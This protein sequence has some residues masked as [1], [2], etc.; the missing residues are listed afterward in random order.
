M[1]EVVVVHFE[2]DVSLASQHFR[3][4]FFVVVL[5]LEIVHVENG[6]L[7]T[8][9]PGR[10]RGNAS[11]AANFDGVPLTPVPDVESSMAK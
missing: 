10:E 7:E 4:G 8:V 6:D 2:R 11:F 9:Y 1:I 5:P 3:A